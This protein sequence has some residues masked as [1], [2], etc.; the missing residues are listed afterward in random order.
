MKDYLYSPFHFAILF[1]YFLVFLFFSIFFF[2]GIPFAFAQLGIPPGV[3][4]FLFW[5][6]LIGSLI[7][8]PITTLPSKVPMV[9]YREVRFWGITYRVPY[10]TYE[11]TVL[12]INFGGAIIPILISFLV[13]LSLIIHHQFSL[14]VKSLIGVLI[15]SLISYHFARPVK[16]VGIALPALL[17]PL[18]AALT[19]IFIAPEYPVP[20]A[21]ISGTLGTLIGAD[22]MHLKDIEKLGAPVASIGG[23]GTFDGI[24]LSGIIAV[25]LVFM[26]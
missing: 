16:G 6:A 5:L 10:T 22:L 7:N 19:A 25:L 17:P 13:F 23:A 18:L 15:V 14:I 8:I 11:N 20:V 12:A 24:F 21:Y 3:A 26:V 4:I 2:L 1:I 9:R